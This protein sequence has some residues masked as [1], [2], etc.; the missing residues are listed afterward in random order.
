MKIFSLL[1]VLLQQV[2]FRVCRGEVRAVNT[3]MCSL[4]VNISGG[5]LNVVIFYTLFTQ[6]YSSCLKVR[7]L[8]KV[9]GPRE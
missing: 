2:P 7:N 6:F 5:N 3:G 1:T 4:N 9:K 8:C